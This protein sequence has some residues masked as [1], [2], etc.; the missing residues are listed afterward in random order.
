[1]NVANDMNKCNLFFCYLVFHLSS[2]QIAVIPTPDMLR[3]FELNSNIRV[4]CIYYDY[5]L[6][7]ISLMGTMGTKPTQLEFSYITRWNNHSYKFLSPA[8]FHMEK[9]LPSLVPLSMTKTQSLLF[10]STVLCPLFCPL[11]S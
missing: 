8:T 3:D 2:S 6:P 11:P 4:N 1:M 7:H 10:P 5:D 9:V